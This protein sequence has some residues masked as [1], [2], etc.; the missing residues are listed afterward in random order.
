MAD[1]AEHI[2]QSPVKVYQVTLDEQEFELF[3]KALAFV[4]DLSVM[5]GQV[6]SHEDIVQK[7]W[8][9]VS[10]LADGVHDLGEKVQAI[11]LQD[12]PEWWPEE[13]RYHV[14]EDRL[15]AEQI[16]ELARDNHLWV[17]AFSAIRPQDG[18]LADI[19]RSVVYKLNQ[20]YLRTTG[21]GEPDEKGGKA[22]E[23]PVIYLRVNKS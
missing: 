2:V 19:G 23:S 20:T 7:V 6:G 3:A 12:L 14:S 22:G 4:E 10:S 18:F 9:G 5:I 17:N 15:T 16:V 11:P 21:F 8:D 13:D 1:I